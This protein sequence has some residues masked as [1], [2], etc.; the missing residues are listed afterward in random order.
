MTS[1]AERGVAASLLLPAVLRVRG[2]Q[3]LRL[4]IVTAAHQAN[5]QIHVASSKKRMRKTRYDSP[6]SERE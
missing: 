4:K 3:A 5:A 2:R 1:I 6:R